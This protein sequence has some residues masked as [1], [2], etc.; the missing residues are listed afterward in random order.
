[1]QQLLPIL[2]LLA[3][4]GLVI[5]RLPKIDM[6][7]SEAFLRRRV[8]NWVPMGLLYSF[9]YMGRYNLTVAKDVFA[10]R[11]NNE[12]FATIF[13]AGTWVYGLA[14]LINGPLTDRFGGRAAILVAGAG[15]IAAN[16]AMGL[17]TAS[18]YDGDLR[19]VFGVLYSMNMYFQ[20]FGAVAIVKCNAPW[21]YV[22]ERGAIGALFGILISLGLY[23][24]YDWGAKIVKAFPLEYVFYIP[25]ALLLAL[26][27]AVFVLVRDTPAQAGFQDF[28]TGDAT[29]DNEGKLSVVQVFKK[30]LSNK[31]ILTI[32]VIEFCSG[33]LR[34][35]V[36]QWYRT[37]CKQVGFTHGFVYENWGMLLCCAGIL[38]GVFAGYVSDHV[39]GSRR[40]PVAAVLYGALLAIAGVMVFAFQVDAALGWL[41][42]AFSMAVIGVHG[43]LSGTASMDFG[44]RKNTGVAVGLIDGFVY[45]GTG[46][47]SV[48]YAAI[49]PNGEAA[50]VVDNWHIWP[51]SLIPVALIGLA[52]A[53]TLW[54]A[55]ASNKAGAH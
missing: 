24:A 41:A 52:L 46:A 54:N 20:S 31:V 15:S 7:H 38:G 22:K 23:F 50:K 3:A 28:D 33:F 19:L 39:F 49:L 26:C 14:F 47:M 6:G 2:I 4:I 43:M 10:E 16:L 55:R 40:G 36:M 44:G 27:V 1:M 29:D 17:V 13:A 12:A 18:G 21:F 8:Q 51:I 25:S 11:M 9:L 48:I 30:M 53:A 5:S 34:Q 45:A 35:A 37:F 32:A 42:V